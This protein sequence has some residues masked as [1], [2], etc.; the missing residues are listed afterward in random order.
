LEIKRL[1]KAL[2]AHQLFGQE[3]DKG[4]ETALLTIFQTFSGK[5][6]YSSIEEKAAHLFYFIIKD[7]PFI[8]GNKRIGSF[9][10]IRFLDINK[11]LYL[12]DGTLLISEDT[13][14]AL[15]LLVAQ[16]DPKDKDLMI[17]LILNLI[18]MS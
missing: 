6:L 10:F 3:R 1:R 4:L 11:L 17:K 8:D 5:E 16:S 18:T 13:L 15:A 14:V 12:A 9:M 7:H 2:R